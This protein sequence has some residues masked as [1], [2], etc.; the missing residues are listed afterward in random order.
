MIGLFGMEKRRSYD[1]QPE[2]QKVNIFSLINVHTVMIQITMKYIFNLF[3][4]LSVNAELGI[5]LSV[6]LP[7]SDIQANSES[8]TGQQK[9]TFHEYF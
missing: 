9:T 6:L 3:F 2:S 5:L 4:I 8:M 1:K 7:V